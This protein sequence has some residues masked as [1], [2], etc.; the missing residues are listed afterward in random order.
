M[1][2]LSLPLNNLVDNCIKKLRFF[3]TSL[4]LETVADYQHYSIEG[5]TIRSGVGEVIHT[6][7]RNVKTHTLSED[8]S[9]V[10]QHTKETD[11]NIDITL[12][13]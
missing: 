10:Y 6:S 9:F 5:C 7:D 12:P 8:R 4:V 3:T 13:S 1:I 11:R 2:S